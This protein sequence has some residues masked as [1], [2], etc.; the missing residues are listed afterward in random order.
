[1]AGSELKLSV[2]L[3]AIDKA[4]GPFRRMMAG[5]KGVAGAIRAQQIALRKLNDQ[6]RSMDAFRAMEAQA[7]GT[8]QALQAQRR[9]LAELSAQYNQAAQPSAKMTRE[10]KAQAAQ[11]GKLVQQEDRQKAALQAQRQAL[12]ASGIDTNRL[13]IHQRRL[14][15]EIDGANRKLGDQKAQLWRLQRASDAAAKAHRAGMSAA[16]HG[17][18]AMY[19]GQ[20]AAALGLMPLQAYAAQEDAAMQL[21]A[22]MMDASGR[23]SAEFVR[24]DALAQRLGNRLPGT[25]T[26]FYEMMTMLRRQ[27]MSAKVILGGLGEATAYLGVQLKMGYSEAAE[28]AAKLQDATRTS[29]RDM[30][31]LSDRIQR[32]FYLGVDPNNMLQGFSKLTPAMDVLRIQGIKAADAFAPLLVMADQAGMKGEAAGNAYRKVF[33]GAM[34]AAKQAKANALISGSGIKL[35]F[36]DGRGEFGGLQQMYAQLEK[37]RGISTQER[38]AYLKKQ[39]GDDAETLQVLSLMISKGVAGYAEVQQRMGA[40][41]SLQERVNAQLGT[42]RNLWEAAAG[43]FTN[44]LASVGEA[45]APDIKRLTEWLTRLGERFQTFAQQNPAVVGALGKIALASAALVTVLGGLLVAGGFAAMAF[46]QIHNAVAILSGGKGF[47]SLLQ[48]GGQFAGRVLPWILNGARML[49]PLLGGISA[50]VLAIGAAIAV[51]AALVWKYWGPIKAFMVGVWQGLTDAAAPVMAE[52]RTS[53]A[54]LAPL[55]DMLSSAMGKAWNWI[56]QLFTPFQATNAQLQNATSY[57]RTFGQV[58][59][60]VLLTQIRLLVKLVGWAASAFMTVHT[61]VVRVMGG[62]WSYVKGAWA[63]VT[64]I[65]SGDG[66]KIR[67]GLQSMWTG[68]NQVLAGWPAKMVQAGVAMV[69]GLI[70]G[71]KSMLGKAGEAISGV[72]SGVITRFKSLLGIRSPSRVFAQFGQFTMQGFANGLVRAQNGPLSAMAGMGNRLRQAGAGVALGAIAAPSVA[73]DHRAPISAAPPTLQVAGD[74][75]H[76]TINVGSGT[77]AAEIEQAVRAALDKVQR[78]KAAR[79]RASLSDR[80]D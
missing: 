22:A 63:L 42:M 62:I 67:A 44:G 71:I 76:F 4:T 26:D 31:A 49:L 39:F 6:Q 13:A 79:L 56:K 7:V 61:V 46:S 25:T 17:A 74:T 19:G 2:V 28:F 45:M 57:G 37:L 21:R 75:Y 41:A 34:D 3:A 8:S 48:T 78:E 1:M 23:V 72:G 30:M 11:V 27:G 80:E 14:A 10:L 40:Q 5:S 36:T 50:P 15:G 24:I 70:T 20:R 12:A 54:P 58:L 65:F 33:Q 38:L 69:T 53:L 18:G 73:I 59:G 29:E 52:L 35:D 55:W 68:I 47:V 43:T 32:G 51:V 16:L 64:G 77:A 9:R 60:T 66:A